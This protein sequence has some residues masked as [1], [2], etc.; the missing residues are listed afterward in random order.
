M[1]GWV[2]GHASLFAAL[3]DS[4]K[5]RHERR[6]MYE[7]IVDVPRLTARLPDD[8]PGHPLLSRLATALSEHY[9]AHL[10]STTMALYRDGRDSVAW[11]RDKELRDRPEA[12]VAIVSLGEP[13]PF[14]LRPFGG[15]RSISYK[16][17]WG[18]LLVMGGSCQH[19]FEHAV[20]K[21]CAAGPR[22]SVM[23]RERRM[24]ADAAWLPSRPS[25]PSGSSNRPGN[26]SRRSA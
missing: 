11:H 9:A 2:Q 13:R 18:D 26:E 20:P 12:L 21:T 17:G 8:G 22:I 4:T 23:F 14:V 19:D 7:R 16:P 1:P 3:R 10:F 25:P 15:G 6:R 5:W 24:A